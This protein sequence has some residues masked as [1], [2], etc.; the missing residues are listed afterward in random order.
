[1]NLHGERIVLRALG[2][3][4]GKLLL[5]LINDP[6]I[7]YMLGGWS[8]PVSPEAQQHWLDNL[9]N[10]KNTLRCVICDAEN[11]EAVGVI[12]LTDIDWKNGNAEIHIKLDKTAHGKGFAQDAVNTIVQY[13]FEELRLHLIYA[14]VNSFNI[15]S[16]KLF[17]RCNFEEEGIHRQRIFKKG[18]FEDVT[19]LSII[20]QNKGD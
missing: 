20:N 2:A 8:F 9:L 14:H 7:E 16:Q 4:D 13:A 10:E 3:S 12:M 17:A 11:Q 6:S 19:V 18:R 15:A 1:M 5:D